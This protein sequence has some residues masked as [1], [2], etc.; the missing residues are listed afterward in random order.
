MDGEGAG[1]DW[2]WIGHGTAGTLTCVQVGEHIPHEH[3]YMFVRNLHAHNCR[4]LVLSW[5]NLEQLGTAHD[6]LR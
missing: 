5:A 4:G 1:K 6:W 3:E 2:T